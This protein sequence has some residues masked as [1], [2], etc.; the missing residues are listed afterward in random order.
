MAEG[1]LQILKRRYARGEMT[2][3]DFERM[4]KDLSAG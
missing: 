2:K 1:P 4:K 3:E